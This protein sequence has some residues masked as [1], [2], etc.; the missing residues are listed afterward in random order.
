MKSTF[1][2]PAGFERWLGALKLGALR[3]GCAPQAADPAPGSDKVF[4]QVV[5]T[6][7]LSDPKILCRTAAI[8]YL[9]ITLLRNGAMHSLK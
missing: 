9:F 1:L 7:I 4:K 5:H 3:L 8:F 6:L 2:R